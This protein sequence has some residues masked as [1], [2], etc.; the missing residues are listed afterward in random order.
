M[1]VND[2]ANVVDASHGLAAGVAAKLPSQLGRLVAVLHA[3]DSPDERGRPVSPGTIERGIELTEYFRAHAARVLP[4]FDAL[5]SGKTA[6]V[7]V[8]VERL[9]R[10]SYPDWV[11]RGELLRGLGNVMSDDLTESLTL[12]ESSEVIVKRTVQTG[13]KP[14]DEFQI[15]R[16]NTSNDSNF[17]FSSVKEI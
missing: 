6:G 11:S 10:R 7:A 15:H 17:L 3:L 1:W 4:V 13:T 8:R 14:R 12:L 2:N 9:L 5:A 16:S